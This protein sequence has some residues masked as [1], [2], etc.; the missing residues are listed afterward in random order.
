MT[1]NLKKVV[2]D[3]N[4]VDVKKSLPDF[5]KLNLEL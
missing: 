3:T 4:A 1:P 5:A 2:G